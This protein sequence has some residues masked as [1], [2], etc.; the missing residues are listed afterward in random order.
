[1]TSKLSRSSLSE[2]L[3]SLFLTFGFSLSP[4]IGLG[5]FLI[6]NQTCK[7]FDW[8][9]IL[10]LF[11]QH[12]NQKKSDIRQLLRGDDSEGDTNAKEIN[13]G[14]RKVNNLPG[15]ELNFDPNSLH[16]E[17]EIAHDSPFKEI[18][19]DSDIDIGREMVDGILTSGK[20]TT[21]EIQCQEKLIRC[22]FAKVDI[23]DEF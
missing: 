20:K 14:A 17:F 21:Y 5:T 6:T 3:D 23:E 9:K 8:T 2:L 15:R 16:K 1:M 22:A 19:E 7:S 13:I 4:G 18:D 11:F 10:N 12:L